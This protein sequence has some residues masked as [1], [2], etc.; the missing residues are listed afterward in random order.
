MRE[1]IDEIREKMH[2]LPR[3]I[4]HQGEKAAKEMLEVAID[5]VVKV[6]KEAIIRAVAESKWATNWAAGLLKILGIEP[7]TEEYRKLLERAKIEAAKRF[8]GLKMPLLPIEEFAPGREELLKNYILG[9]AEAFGVDPVKL[10][11]SVPVKRY[12]KRLDL[13]EYL[14]YL[15]KHPEELREYAWWLKK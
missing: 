13:E 10:L 15:K 4:L 5:G 2:V 11:D 7:G 14:E 8:L 6:P 9:L 12:A 3:M 1:L